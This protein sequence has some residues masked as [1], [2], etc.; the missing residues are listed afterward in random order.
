[1]FQLETTLNGKSTVLTIDPSITLVDLIRD[2]FG[3]LGTKIGCRE[4]E[5]GSCTVLLDGL[6]VNACLVPAIKAHQRSVTTVE[7]I[8]TISEPHPIQQSLADAG[9][10]Q[11]GYCT[12][13]IVM[14]AVGL[15]EKNPNPSQI[16]IQEAIAG[17]LC[18]CTGYKRIVEGIKLASSEKKE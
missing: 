1:M 10:V 2:H 8:G 18:R 6:A 12:P 13:G 3:L 15:L 7:G 17:N 14:S 4:G 16:E 5:C 9:G 11:C